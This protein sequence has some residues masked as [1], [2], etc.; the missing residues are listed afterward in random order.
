MQ[1]IDHIKSTE[2]AEHICSDRQFHLLRNAIALW[3]E[4]EQC[5]CMKLNKKY[6]A[7][8]IVGTNQK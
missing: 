2:S 4:P 3:G 1:S 6:V 7:T 5:S 8:E